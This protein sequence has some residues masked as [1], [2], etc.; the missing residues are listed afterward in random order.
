MEQSTSDTFIPNF[1]LN[2]RRRPP[3]VRWTAPGTP[4]SASPSA[5]TALL[6]RSP[7]TTT[8]PSGAATR[9]FLHLTAYT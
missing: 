4:S 2:G 3:K 5:S 9:V 6:P 1:R 7:A 8:T